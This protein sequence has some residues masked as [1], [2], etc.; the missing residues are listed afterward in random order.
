MVNR[1][2]EGILFHTETGGNMER[3]A[4]TSTL[5]AKASSNTDEE[6]VNEIIADWYMMVSIDT[7][8]RR[9]CLCAE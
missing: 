2:Y 9:D 4:W 8:S 7:M 5:I 6:L 1:G 3:A